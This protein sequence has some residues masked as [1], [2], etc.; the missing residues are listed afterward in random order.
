MSNQRH[1]EKTSFVVISTRI[2]RNSRVAPKVVTFKKFRFEEE[3]KARDLFFK[4]AFQ[5][6]IFD[7]RIS[8]CNDVGVQLL[9]ITINGDVVKHFS[10]FGFNTIE[11]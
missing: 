5:F 6:R 1:I 3:Q 7:H 2:R 8:L 11:S 4:E 10:R 9:S